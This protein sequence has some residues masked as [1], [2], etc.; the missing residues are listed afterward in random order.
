MMDSSKV[1]EIFKEITRI[2]RE[3][4]HEEAMRAYLQKFAKERNLACKTDEVG[5]VCITKEASKGKENVPA[6][7]LQ[8]HQDMVCEKR[9]GV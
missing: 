6:L 8:G 5:N 1:L 9:S 2:P 3:S 7:V 4:G